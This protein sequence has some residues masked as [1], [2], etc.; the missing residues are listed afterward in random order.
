MVIGWRLTTSVM[1]QS[2]STFAILLQQCGHQYGDKQCHATARPLETAV[3]VFCQI[4]LN[5][6]HYNVC[7]K[8]YRVHPVV[9]VT[10]Y[11]K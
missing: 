10:L 5:P 3:L 7:I 11:V 2:C 8:R 9:L 4:T 1:A 6:F